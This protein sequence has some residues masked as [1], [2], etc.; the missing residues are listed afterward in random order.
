MAADSVRPSGNRGTEPG[1]AHGSPPRRLASS[2]PNRPF[3][4][5]K[6][7]STQPRSISVR[8]RTRRSVEPQFIAET[9]ERA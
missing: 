9:S 5:V 2:L 7:T 4:V 3:Q 8:S 6:N 1:F